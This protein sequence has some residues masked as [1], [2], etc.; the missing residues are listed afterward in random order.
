MCVLG[1]GTS[2]AR[3]CLCLSCDQAV[4]ARTTSS[5][6]VVLSTDRCYQNSR[7]CVT[8]RF[9]NNEGEALWQKAI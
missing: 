2:Q 4:S 5:G 8:A 1:H 9:S 6:T 7:L 3:L